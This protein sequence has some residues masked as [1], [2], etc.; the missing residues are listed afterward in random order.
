MIELNARL[1]YRHQ[2]EVG[3]GSLWDE[4]KQRL[5]WV[6]IHGNALHRYNPA[7][8]KNRSWNVGEHVG[9]VVLDEQGGALLATVR[10][11]ARFN[12]ETGELARLHDPEV[13]HDETRFNDGKCDPAGRFWAGTMAYDCTEGAGNLYCLEADGSVGKKLDQLTISNGLVWNAAATKFYFIDSLTYQVDSFDYDRATGEISNKS[14]VTTF[15]KDTEGLPDGMAIDVEGGL[16]VAMFG[17]SAVLRIDPA[18][19]ERTHKV[20]LPTANVT[21]CAFGGKDL[22]DL[23]ITT[24]T[25][26]LNDE[27]LR[28]QPLAGSLFVARSP[29]AGVPAHRYV[30]SA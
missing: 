3:E 30:S 29:I 10:G 1:A 5:Y 14:V 7:T 13:G 8:G 24:A 9:T 11:F 12:L 23:Y 18:T 26:H 20:S 28:D 25:V 19:G 16:W 4:L 27:Q 22:K 15:D 17:K 21:S 6:D 2:A